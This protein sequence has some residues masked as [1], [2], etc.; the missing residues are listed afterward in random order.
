MLQWMGGSRRKVTISRK[1]T[2]N[3]QRQYFEQRKQQKQTAGS[4]VHV[5]E[6]SIAGLHHKECQSLDILSLLN[7]STVSSEGSN[8]KLG[9]PTMKY[10]M[11]KDPATIISSSA[12]HSVK[13]KEAGAPPLSY[14]EELQ[15]PKVSF[16]DHENP[17]LNVSN[18]NLD[19]RNAATENRSHGKLGAS[20]MKY[21]MPKDPAIVV[22]S[23]A[24]PYSV[25][26]KEAGAPPSSY[27]GELQYPK[28]S[29][30]DHENPDLN[31]SNSSLDL[32][33][34]ATENQLSIFDMLINDESEVI[35]E[36]SLVHE[37]HVAFSVEGLGKSRTETPLHSPKQ[38][39]RIHSDECSLR[40]KTSRQLNSSK[41]SNYVLNDIELEVDA[42]IQDMDIPLGGN[43]SQFSV[44][45][46]E[47]CNWKPN[48]SSF[49]DNIQ[50]DSLSRNRECSFGD[51]DISYNIRR[52]DIWDA[53]C[54]DDDF[55]HERE[56]GISWKY[57]PHKINGNSGDILDY[58][59]G[60]MSDN[61][62]ES[63]HMPRKRD[64][65]GTKLNNLDPSPRRLSS[66]VGHDF[67]TLIGVSGR[68]NPIKRNHDIRDLPDWP[69][70][71]TGDATDST[72][73]L[74]EE[75]CSSSAVHL[76]LEHI[77][78]AVDIDFSSSSS[79]CASEVSLPS[80]GSQV[81]TEDPF[82]VSERQ[83]ALIDLSNKMVA[84]V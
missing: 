61:T 42:M 56:D 23:S 67:T 70:F 49:S 28:V 68:Y 79:R 72:S 65:K 34:A 19:L 48:L 51:T 44:D 62:F 5:D 30:W 69:L 12:P 80:V 45:I 16:W 35:S 41:C 81:W 10:Q 74:S 57:W 6:T 1:S 21:Q 64:V 18:N 14:Q 8:G 55:L 22:S 60:E 29:F 54:L 38:E 53:S 20:T 84:H 4:E 33:N 58:E 17:D 83:P 2:Q 71:E 36:R 47:H 3:R 40:W 37:A 63:H 46:T 73:L 39:G 9:A 78:K 13:I 32:R 27:Q 82:R 24:P 15:Y 43:P 59:N 25:N 31:V 76:Q 66:K 7:V 11:P 50:L 77:A 75:S 52:E 26:I